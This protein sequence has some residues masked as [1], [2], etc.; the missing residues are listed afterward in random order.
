MKK[1]K[2]IIKF[3][4]ICFCV[5][6]I[7]YLSLYIYAS[8][9]AKLPIDQANSF[10]F[11][12]IENNLY[13]GNHNKEWISLEEMSP[14]IVQATISIEDKNF[15]KHIGFDYL[16]ILK[17]LFI[18][19]KNGKTL[20]GASTITQQYAKNLFLDFDKKWSRKIEEAW[21]TI[22]LEVHYSKDE[23]LEG[24]LNTINYG[25]VF[26]IENAS[27]YYF[28]KSAKDLTLAEATIL[29][30]IPKSP[31][32]Y[33]PINNEN[34]SKNRQTLI[35]NAMVENHYITEE[36][37]KEA[38][39]T[40]LIFT[41]YLEQKNLTTLMY[42]QDAV[43]E[44]LQSLKTIPTS[45]LQTGGLKIYTNLDMNAQSSL[46]KS[47]QDNLK[48]DENLQVSSIVMNPNTGE[49]LALAGGRDYNQSQYN[50]ALKSTRQVGSTMKPFLYYAALENGFTSSTTFTSEETTFA[51][52]ENK[53]Y[54]PKNFNDKYAN[55]PISLAT[56]IAYS[57]NIYAVKTHLFLGEETL[58]DIAKRVGITTPLKEIPSLALGS[59]EISMME[60][61][62]G[63]A[64]FASG[65][66]K[67]EPYFIRKIE[68][69]YGNVLY[70]K[71][72]EKEQVLN[73]SLV[74]ILNE[75]LS[76]TYSSA[77]IDYNY[78]TCLNIAGKL[79]RKYAIKTGTTN[80]DHLI[81]GYN[82]DVLIGAWVGYDDNKESSVDVSNRIKNLW[83]DAME[84]YVK[85]MESDWY[86]IPS[87]VVGVLTD[88]I[89][90]EI[91]TED[92]PNKKIMYYIKGTEPYKE[93]TD[94]DI[95]I[96]TIKE[97]NTEIPS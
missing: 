40:E 21:L 48:E 6:I 80:T 3:L 92:T 30:G 52:S 54:S 34:A 19:I 16:R 50:R 63:Y 38:K 20:Q 14:Y 9:T 47:I 29:A 86:A 66:Y 51:F 44:E 33:S 61:M 22:R 37:A 12:D 64:T 17:A 53:T 49:I 4:L 94:F 89:S 36:Q 76:N 18:N 11:Y 39:E 84:G 25:G 2:R 62:R 65:G 93:D 15:Y 28:N 57:D 8:F 58:V 68:D 35:L 27:K 81:F 45:F 41:G 67:V 71:Y 46:E 55:K 88:P 26:G 5:C 90:G 87:N 91:A 82:K 13:T 75:L 31:T 74:F 59:M 96:P 73:K 10:Y 97:E 95:L 24:Y 43:I 72:P 32:Y 56:A 78:P 85:D 7:S 60:M 69:M 79:S 83:A 23:I 1:I 77:F 42:Y 70:E